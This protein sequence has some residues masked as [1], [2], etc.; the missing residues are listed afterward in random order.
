MRRREDEA[1]SVTITRTVGI[2]VLSIFGASIG[3]FLGWN[4]DAISRVLLGGLAALAAVRRTTREAG[5]AA[6][7]VIAA[8]ELPSTVLPELAELAELASR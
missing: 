8:A 6:G 3:A 4:P 2:V 1:D 7:L 5:I